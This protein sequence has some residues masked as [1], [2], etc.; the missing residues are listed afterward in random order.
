MALGGHIDHRLVRA[1]AESLDIPLWFYADYPYAVDDPLNHT[2]LRG[3]LSAY[4]PALVQALSPQA[5]AA[6]Q[7]AIAAYASQISSFWGS[8]DEM[9]ARIAAYYLEGGGC[10]LWQPSL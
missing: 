4:H 5:V 3:D 9:R 6:W 8:L 1:A 10:V 7:S 2:D